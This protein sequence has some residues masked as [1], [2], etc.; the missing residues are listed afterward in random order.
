MEWDFE[1]VAD[2]PDMTVHTPDTVWLQI[3]HG[4]LDGGQALG[5]GLYRVEGDYA[6]LAKMREWFTRA[7]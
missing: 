6:V 3:A 1:G 7:E 4:K 5:E 2:R